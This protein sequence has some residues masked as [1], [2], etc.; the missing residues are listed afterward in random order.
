METAFFL[1]MGWC[2]TGYPGWLRYLLKKIPPP[3]DPEPWW[4]IGIIGLGLVAGVVGGHYFNDAIVDNQFFAG[5][6][7]IASGLFAFGASNVT[8]GIASSLKR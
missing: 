7:A 1:I 8:T 3:P 6:N 5:Q 4:H 2:G